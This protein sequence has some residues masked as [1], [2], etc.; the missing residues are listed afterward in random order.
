MAAGP[1]VVRRRASRRISKC[2]GW[3]FSEILLEK[4]QAPFGKIPKSVWKNSGIPLEKFQNAFG[5]IPN[6]FRKNS[7]FQN[8]PDVLGRG[9]IP[10]PKTDFGK[11][12]GSSWKNSGTPPGKNP[13]IPKTIPGGRPGAAGGI[14]RRAARGR[15]R[16]A[17]PSA[18]MTSIRGIALNGVPREL[19][20]ANFPGPEQT[21]A[22][23]LRRRSDARKMHR[24]HRAN[25]PRHGMHLRIR[26]WSA[27][28]P[29]RKPGN[30]EKHQYQYFTLL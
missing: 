11:I 7:G 8:S 12:P 13:D 22:P 9:R 16:R 5:K 21:A 15:T 26:P 17:P 4:S 25:N 1:P 14:A 23:D 2:E 29:A 18:P 19:R 30:P 27:R 6:S 24:A 10:P 28:G 20:L 3:R